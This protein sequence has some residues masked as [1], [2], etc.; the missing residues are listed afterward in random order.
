MSNKQ[1]EKLEKLKSDFEKS[2]KE[3]Y[4]QVWDKSYLRVLTFE[5]KK[6]SD[7][8]I[9]ILFIAGFLTIFPRWEKVIKELTQNYTVYYVETREKISSILVK[10]AG[11]TIKD[12]GKDIA[13]LEK[14]LDIDNEQYI[15]ISSSMGGAM[16]LE[17]LAEKRISPLGN[18]LFSPGVELIFPKWAPKITRILPAFGIIMLKPFI[19]WYIKNKLVDSE[20][21][22]EQAKH[23]TRSMEEADI[24]KMRKCIIKNANKYNGWDLLPKVHDRIILVGATTDKAHKTEFSE[25]VSQGLSNCTFIDLGTS[26]AA[27]DTPLV[28]LTNEFV[29][30]LT[31]RGPVL[32]TRLLEQ[33]LK[34]NE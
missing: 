26:K 23:Y 32:T 13:S 2:A 27:H 10:R 1:L 21:E 19:R 17:N 22:P 20:K 33:G 28:D 6:S 15:T 11:M 30:E 4:F 9:K 29:K 31:N 25:K 14:A 18:I 12:M 8:E 3:E 7:E 24:R 34:S 16:I 5:K